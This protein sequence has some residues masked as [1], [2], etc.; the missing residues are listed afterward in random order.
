MEKEVSV[1]CH[2][3]DHKTIELTDQTGIMLDPVMRVYI[4]QIKRT[5][6]IVS[7]E[8]Y[9]HEA[10]DKD[11]KGRCEVESG[12]DGGG[13]SAE[14]NI[15]T[16]TRDNSCNVRRSLLSTGKIQNLEGC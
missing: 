14:G 15:A 13:K 6:P 2:S 9:G 10:W 4:L 12:T 7:S 5:L 11:T 3:T 1:T 8:S 16:I